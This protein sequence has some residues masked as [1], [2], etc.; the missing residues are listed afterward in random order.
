MKPA[1]A[2]V[3]VLALAPPTAAQVLDLQP[4]RNFPSATSAFGTGRT[5]GVDIADADHD[6][7]LD[8]AVANGMYAPQAN[9]IYIN[10]GGV[11]G[12]LTGTFVDET[13]TRFAGF[14]DDRSRDLEFVDYDDDGDLDLYFTN[15]GNTVNGGGVSRAFTNQG[16]MQQGAVGYYAEHT[17]D[18]WGDLV[19]VPAAQQ[20][21]GGDHGPF[22]D[23]PCD[24]SFGDLDLDG[25][26]DLFHSTYG[27]NISGT[28][29]SR[30]F[31]NDGT[32]TFDELWPWGDALADT[33]MH[34]TDVDLADLDG[35]FDLDVFVASRNSQARVFRNNL[36]VEAM[37]W[38]GDP[39]TDV[40]Q[41][42]LLDQGAA[43]SGSNNYEVEV[44]DLDGDGDFDAWMSNYANLHDRLLLNDGT[45]AFTIA[46][47]A[48]LG[49]SNEEEE[50]AD[51][52]DFDSDGDLDVFVGS[53]SGMNW[54]Y[55]NSLADSSGAVFQ[56]HRTGTPAG[57][58]QAIWH[59]TPASGNGGTTDAAESADLDGDGDPDLVLGNDG[60]QINRLWLNALGVPDTHA[61]S[62]HLLTVQGD[63]AD[64]RDTPIR[65]QLRDNAPQRT[66]R[67]YAVDLVFRVDGGLPVRVPMRSQRGQ[68]FQATIPGG[69]DGTI[70]WHVEGRDEAGNVFTSTEASYVQSSSGVTAIEPVG[71][72]TPGVA[73][74]P[75]LLV[76]GDLTGGSIVSLSLRDGPPSATSLL[77]ASLA[78]TPVPFKG[79]WLHTVPVLLSI[80][81]PT[82][83]AGSWWF[84][85][86]WPAGLPSGALL[87][88]Q[89]A[90]ADATA[91]G[92]ASL[93]N[94]VKLSMP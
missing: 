22:R 44:A 94:A 84:D 31:L 13:D 82:D 62:V 72:G 65:V 58:S 91:T 32:G 88:S 79:G 74:Y 49:D 55:Q 16:G 30:V 66:I 78:S 9:R 15:E 34:A 39:F 59:E 38:N 83:A 71:S 33:K 67:R 52:L 20:V 29:D 27:P 17:D 89:V 86:T 54:L 68:Q 76:S 40:T 45:G 51:V 73:G 48:I 7:D 56:L 47:G 4:G 81:L 92:G 25:D 18:F 35:D 41:S 6:G 28:Y 90:M 26:P 70:A 19:S 69:I 57:G 53:F 36:T 23:F 24:C 60:N 10:Q 85:L 50:E 80:A 93:S 43:L 37:G 63:K 1:L 75:D 42:A 14:V 64:G 46:L 12:G 21:F 2:L 61:P 8:V 87:W 11:Q 3:A 5:G 77:F